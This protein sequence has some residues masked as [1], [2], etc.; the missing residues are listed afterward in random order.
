MAKLATKAVRTR[1][2][3]KSVRLWFDARDAGKPRTSPCATKCR[4]VW[5]LG[6]EAGYSEGMYDGESQEGER[7]RKLRSL[8]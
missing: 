3:N 8:S 4:H 6:Y 7:V 5:C 2:I 1:K